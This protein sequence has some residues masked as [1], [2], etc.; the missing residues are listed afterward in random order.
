MILLPKKHQASHW[1]RLTLIPIVLLLCLTIIS[2]SPSTANALSVSD[3]IDTKDRQYV[4]IKCIWGNKYLTSTEGDSV[5]KYSSSS[6]STDRSSHWYIE[7]S[8]QSGRYW[9][10]SRTTSEALHVQNQTGDIQIGTLKE[11]FTSYRWKFPV[12]NDFFRIQNSWQLTEYMSV[13]DTSTDVVGYDALA[14][15]WF[16]LRFRIETV[17]QGAALPW[18]TYD[19]SNHSS[20]GGGANELSPTYYRNAIQA[21]AQNRSAVLL[22]SYG[23]YVGWTLSAAADS[24]TLRY[25]VPD[26]ATGGGSDGTISMYVNGAYDSRIDVTSKQAWVYFDV[27]MNEYD[28]PATGRRPAKRYNEARIKFSAALTAND[29]IEFR[30]DSGDRLIWIDL[31]EAELAETIVPAIASEFYDVTSYG[32]IADDGTDDRAAFLSCISAAQTDSKGVYIPAGTFHLSNKLE[33]SD[34]QIL[35]AGIWNTELHFTDAADGKGGIN[36]IGS[37]ITVSDFYMHAPIAERQNYKALR[38]YWGTGSRIENIWIDQFAVGAWIADYTG[39][40]EETDGLVIRNCRIRNTFADGI[41]LAKG[42]KNTLVE[43]CHIRTTGDDSLA[44]WSSDPTQVDIC[45]SNVLRY[46]TIECTYRAAGI[47]VFGGQ[48]H[49]IHHN[50]V[51]DVVSG[52]GMRFNT[53]FAVN[54]YTFSSTGMVEV[55]QN[56]LY[57]TGTTNGWGYESGAI[58]LRTRFGDVQNIRFS[59]ITVD[60]VK[61]YGIRIDHLSGTGTSGSFS[62]IEFKDIDLQ[63]VIYGTYVLN[64]A[65]GDCDFTNVTV[66]LHPTYGVSA[67]QNNS[68]NFS[69]VDHGGNSGL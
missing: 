28:A 22:D 68:A 52:A 26:T 56:S 46:N 20:I 34:I 10:R 4:R 33:L 62:N 13:E 24:F 18:T 7:E 19:E 60:E 32:A 44:S 65:V 47:G 29:T 16:S 43:N 3:Y 5:I 25:A 63:A 1:P 8:S 17:E 9:I 41:N 15:A 51:R 27:N 54:G 40:I 57:R 37:N 35:G 59:D 39:T 14:T 53:T 45:K 12:D 31:L 2:F 48:E 69:I 67:V 64:D 49:I 66:T 55:Y 30:R 58:S 6:E 42:T 21:E 38:G 11:N 61:D 23:A 50:V 36:G